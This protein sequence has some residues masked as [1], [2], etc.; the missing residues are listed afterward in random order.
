MYL[1][2]L[3]VHGLRNLKHIQLSL[4]P[5]VNLFH[6]PNGSGKT[7]ILE[8]IFLL[9]RGRSFRSRVLNTV[10]NTQEQVC[11]AYGLRESAGVSTPIGVSRGR[12]GDF[13][14]KI[15]GQQISAASA[16]AETLPLLLL[17]AEGFDL[18]GGGPQYRRRF[19]DWGVF[20]VEHNYKQLVRRYQRVLKQR[21]SLMRHDRIDEQMLAVWDTE[22]VDLAQ[23]INTSR[24]TY[25]NDLLPIVK[26]VACELSEDLGDVDFAV[27]PGWDE[28]VGLAEVLLKDR[29]R[30]RLLKTT[31]HGPHRADLRIRIK[32]QNVSDILSR[33]QLKVLAT[34]MQVAQGYLFYNKTGRSGLYLIDDLP[35]ELDIKHRQQVCE[36]LSA[37]GAQIF[38]TGVERGDL[39]N[40][41]SESTRDLRLFHVEQGSVREEHCTE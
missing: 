31:H 2:Q 33:G 30:D 10:I 36:K 24:N 6:G 37:L 27:H 29:P 18:I 25:L 34:A 23:Q 8:A 40:L 17:N 38:V 19:I 26:Q 3:H 13:L 35:A 15:N 12:Q 41:W 39:L 32:K 1:K 11:T 4:S 28:A 16:L 20:H 21:N 5:Q 22:F 9:G 7:S 14:F